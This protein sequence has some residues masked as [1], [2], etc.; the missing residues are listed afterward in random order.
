[1]SNALKIGDRVRVKAHRLN[2]RVVDINLKIECS[3]KVVINDGIVS[4]HGWYRESE[5]TI[6]D[7]ER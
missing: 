6:V 5:L 7:K 3:F 2:G 4:G 1:M